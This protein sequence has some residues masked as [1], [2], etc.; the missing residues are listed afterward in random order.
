[1]QQTAAYSVRS[2]QFEGWCDERG[3]DPLPAR[4]EAVAV[5]DRC[6]IRILEIVE[7]E[8]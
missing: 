4:A 1:M 3:L 8:S 2:H 7:K 6:G 5:G